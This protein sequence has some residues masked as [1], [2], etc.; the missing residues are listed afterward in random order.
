MNARTGTVETL[1]VEVRVAIADETDR[2]LLTDA[3]YAASDAAEQAARDADGVEFV[4]IGYGIPR[5][6][7][8]RTAR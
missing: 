7:D 3:L 5:R 1:H 6:L 4:G 8:W 2:K